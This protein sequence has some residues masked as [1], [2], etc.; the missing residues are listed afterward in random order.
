MTEAKVTTRTRRL[1][2][3]PKAAAS[4]NQEDLS[5]LAPAPE[6]TN[7][8]SPAAPKTPTKAEM[9]I[10]L[11]QRPQG[12][13]LEDLIAKTGWLPHTTRAALTGLRKKCHSIAKDKVDAVT[14]YTIGPPAQS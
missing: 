8:T 4:E 2:R 3:T 7:L 1:V 6:I 12:A 9:V 14:R 13:S 5:T 11:L 10:Q